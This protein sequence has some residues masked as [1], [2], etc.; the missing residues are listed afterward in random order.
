M[1]VTLKDI[2]ERVGVTPAT[3]SMVLNNKP[4][5]GKETRRKVLKVAKELNYYPHAIARGLATRRTY[6]IGIVVPSLGYHFVSRV[7][8]GIESGIKRFDYSIVLFDALGKKEVEDQIYKRIVREKRVDG[9]IVVRLDASDETLQEFARED[10]PCVVLDKNTPRSNCL[11]VDDAQ[12]AQQATS[13]L[14]EKGHRNIA[15]VHGPLEWPVFRERKRGYQEALDKAGVQFNPTFLCETHEAEVEDGVEATRKLLSVKSR[16]TAVFCAAGD[17][18][19]AGVISELR[20][21]GFAIPDDVAVVGF[22]DLPIAQ[23]THPPLTTVRQPYFEMGAESVQILF[24]RLEGDRRAIERK[25][26]PTQLVVR[27]SA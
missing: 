16:P 23:V 12:A 14:L 3:V 9:A 13:Y 26:L 24:R 17:V 1:A 19:A 15:L 5:I 21:N 20:R 22:D 18:V 4:N 10:V 2:A 8:L 25:E 6:A 7:L 11:F 27:Q